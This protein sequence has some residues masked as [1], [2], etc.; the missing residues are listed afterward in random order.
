M[1][2]ST[3]AVTGEGKA[4][5]KL[6]LKGKWFTVMTLCLLL[7]CHIVIKDATFVAASIVC[8]YNFLRSQ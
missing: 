2:E 8:T 3:K 1:Q 7:G 4:P 5:R 6:A